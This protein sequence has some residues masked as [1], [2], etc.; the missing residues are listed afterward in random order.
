[1]SSARTIASAAADDAA[2]LL[3]YSVGTNPDPLQASPASGNPAYGALTIVVS[4]STSQYIY[5][6]SIVFSFPEG[7]L[8]QDLT[9]VA[10]GILSAAA[11]S[12]QWQIAN[13]GICQFT[14]TPIQPQ[15]ATIGPAGLVFQI[16]NIQI[17][18]QPGNV[19]FTIQESASMT[20][21]GP[22]TTNTQTV[23]L[24]KFP[25]G[26]FFD[27]FAPVV[28]SIQ[29]GAT[30]TLNWIGTDGPTYTLYYTGNTVDVTLVRTYTTGPLHADTSFLLIAS[31]QQLGETV[32]TSLTTSVNVVNPDLVLTSLTVNGLSTLTGGATVPGV[33]TLSG[34]V[35]AS[36]TSTF[37]GPANLNEVTTLNGATVL[38]GTLQAL[39]ASAAMGN[40]SGSYTAS[41]DGIVIA[42]IGAPANASAQSVGW[43]TIVNASGAYSAATGGNY[44]VSFVNT[45]QG[46][47][48]GTS[49]NNQSAYMPV[50]KGEAFSVV[51]TNDT[52]N[53]ANPT[54]AV[55]FVPF[56]TG[57]VSPSGQQLAHVPLNT[58]FVVEK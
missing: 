29:D 9:D 32:T 8:A 19:T 7:S 52:V 18:Q 13:T 42:T 25:Y 44:V 2:T 31:M 23:I 48:A 16:Y 21:G 33:T 49:S 24:A 5:C 12:T 47:Q 46:P 4:N 22:Y 30:A 41:S 17:N 39:A 3:T 50:R 1:M 57:S 58:A 55:W 45:S 6:Q 28:P 37:T 35:N 43:V 10:T 40:A 54:Y 27:N 38:N 11:P 34:S 14:A 20:S 26:F 56:G 53:T 15:Y 51:I 36:G